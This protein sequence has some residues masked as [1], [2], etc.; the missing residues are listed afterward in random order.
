MFVTRFGLCSD[1]MLG[2]GSVGVVL[3]FSVVSLRTLTTIKHSRDM[4]ICNVGT[5]EGRL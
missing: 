3:A 5:N 4:M 2:R 1:R